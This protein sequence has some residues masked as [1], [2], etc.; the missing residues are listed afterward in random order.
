MRFYLKTYIER[1]HLFYPVEIMR[2]A[3]PK[4]NDVKA[5][6]LLKKMGVTTGKGA[7]VCLYENFYP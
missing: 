3:S 1:D 7:I 4:E 2:T 5:F 6:R